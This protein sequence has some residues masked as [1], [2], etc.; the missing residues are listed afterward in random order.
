MPYLG[1]KEG[2]TMKILIV[3]IEPC[4]GQQGAPPAKNKVNYKAALKS[5]PTVFYA[6]TCCFKLYNIW[7]PT[8]NED[9]LSAIIV[10]LVM[11]YYLAI[12]ISKPVEYITCG[13]IFFA[14]TLIFFMFLL[15]FKF[16]TSKWVYEEETSIWILT[17][18]ILFC[19]LLTLSFHVCKKIVDIPYT[20]CVITFLRMIFWICP[21]LFILFLGSAIY[22][23]IWQSSDERGLHVFICWLLHTTMLAV[24]VDWCLESSKAQLKKLLKRCTPANSKSITDVE[25]VM[26]NDDNNNRDDN[27]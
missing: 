2:I 18:F 20:K 23:A 11:L 21:L 10:L 27:Y 1:M 3:C 26:L 6:F 13:L 16:N 22:T 4:K 19:G 12:S 15:A 8:Y 9:N 5:I 25:M 14:E 24:I 7:K 17:I